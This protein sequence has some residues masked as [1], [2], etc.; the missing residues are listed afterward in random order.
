MGT[1][2][3]KKLRVQ[4][5]GTVTAQQHVSSAVRTRVAQMHL[6]YEHETASGHIGV[7]ICNI[8]KKNKTRAGSAVNG[9]RKKKSRKGANM[10]SS[11]TQPQ[12][13]KTG[14]K[15]SY[16]VTL[17]ISSGQKVQSTNTGVNQRHGRISP[18]AFYDKA[19]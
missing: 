18:R 4:V 11:F 5:D 19:N 10:Y 13:R 12:C 6:H 15:L 3:K 14:T 9:A 2:K 16:Y 7:A 8:E 1:K 17:I